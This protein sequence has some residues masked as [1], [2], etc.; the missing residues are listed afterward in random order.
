MDHEIKYEMQKYISFKRKERKIFSGSRAR[1]RILR[2]PKAQSIKG[3][4]NK[5]DQIN[6]K[7]TCFA[8]AHQKMRNRLGNNCK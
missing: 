6:I 5:T 8:K 4:I 3:K 1:R 7:N 2:T